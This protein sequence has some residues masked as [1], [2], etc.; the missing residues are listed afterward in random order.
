MELENKRLRSALDV[1]SR[2]SVSKHFL[3]SA[4]QP[5][6]REMRASCSSVTY[7]DQI[8]SVIEKAFYDLM[9]DPPIDT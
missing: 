7:I 1:M 2:H 3:L 5:V 8:E 6:F 9:Y 4:L